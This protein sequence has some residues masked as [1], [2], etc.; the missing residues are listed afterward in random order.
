MSEYYRTST[1][2][3]CNT[4]LCCVLD[5]HT[6]EIKRI[7]GGNSAVGRFDEAL[8]WLVAS[9]SLDRYVIVKINC[10]I[11]FHLEVME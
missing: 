11:G 2:Q 1:H 9:G 6:G 7:F 10:V 3:F 8:K 4:E 5:T